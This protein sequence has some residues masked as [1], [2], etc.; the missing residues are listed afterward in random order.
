MKNSLIFTA[1]PLL[2]LAGCERH[3]PNKPDPTKGAVTGIVLCA[4][5]GKPAR[6][7]KVTLTALSTDKQPSND[8][9]LPSNAGIMTGL[10]GRFRIEAVPPGH[11]Y[12]F[13]TLPG[14]LDP[15]KGIDIVHILGEN[16]D[17][18]DQHIATI[19]AWKEHLV[20]VD[21]VAGRDD[22][23]TITIERGAEISGHVTYDDGAPAIGVHFQLLRKSEKYGFSPVGLRLFSSW[24]LATESDSHGRYLLTD[25][26]PGEY[27]VCAMLPTDTEESSPHFCL[28]NV[29]RISKAQ[30]IKLSEEQQLSDVDLIIP[31][32]GLHEV[33]GNVSVQ[34]DG[35]K[36][37]KATVQLLYAD[38]RSVALETSP[39]N[40][41]DFWFDSV[42]EGS[43]ILYVVN[44][45]D[46]NRTS[47]AKDA[48]GKDVVTQLPSCAY[49]TKEIPIELKE[50]VEG[51]DIQL[52]A[53]TEQKPAPSN[54]R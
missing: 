18:S 39:D 40:D 7:A 10:D 16:K 30:T 46:E 48:N 42:P 21:V 37:S 49:P 11:Y 4:D 33:H 50:D 3:P 9:P 45:S 20:E 14:Y 34:A 15:S 23:I 6:F 1:L 19:K 8:E 5:T 47:T 29:F 43:Y 17:E 51:L 41:G 53:C 28:G 35:H 38:D 27:T 54:A 13:A 22:E 12:A 31:L 36:P 52:P 26:A 25:L 24:S 2:L 44:A 32:E